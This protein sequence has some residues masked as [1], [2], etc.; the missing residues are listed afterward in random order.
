MS[1]SECPACGRASF[2][3]CESIDI[4]EQHRSY[5]PNDLQM[6]TDLTAAAAESAL[7]YQMCRCRNCRLEYSD[8]MRAPSAA[9]YQ[10]AYRALDLYPGVRWEFGEVLRHVGAND[11]VF[12]FG[13]GSGSFLTCCKGQGVPALGMDFSMDA[14]ATCLA[15][16]LSAQRLDLNEI[17]DLTDADRFHQMAAFHFLEHLDHPR[18][19]FEQAAARALPSADLWV[20]VPSD[21]RPTR[22]YGIPDFLDQPPHHMSRWTP[23]AFRQIGMQLGWRLIEMLYEP[24]PLRT[25]VWS[26]SVY[27]AQYKRWKRAGRF[28]NRLVEKGYRAAAL[29]VALLR[30]V[31]TDRSLRGFSMLAHFVFD[32][33]ARPC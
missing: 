13:C 15:N 19:L 20:S 11:R 9:W 33:S 24:I 17:A 26:I 12:E 22:L 31:T 23:E 18:V 6:Q 4:V 14:I 10:L 25:A 21:R 5:S 30:R 1:Q 16:G 3:L 7:S 8:P 27:S 29:P 28:K 2:D 32:A